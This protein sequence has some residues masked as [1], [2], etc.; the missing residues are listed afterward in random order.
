MKVRVLTALT[1]IVIALG[2]LFWASPW[3]VIALGLVILLLGFQEIARLVGQKPYPGPIVGIATF[4]FV[5]YEASQGRLGQWLPVL[6]FFGAGS[7]IVAVTTLSLVLHRQEVRRAIPPWLRAELSGFWLT[8]PLLCLLALHQLHP[9]AQ[10]FRFETPILMSLV[11]LWAGDTAAILVGRLIGKTPLA[12]DI[13]PKK[14]VEGGVANLLACIGTCF[15]IGYIIHYSWL[16]CLLCGISAGLLGQYGDLFESWI[17]RDAG[18]KDS[19]SILPGHGGLMDR[20]DSMLFTAPA[21]ALILYYF[22]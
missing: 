22:R 4:G 1:L 21:V 5:I 17:K 6:V 13:S 8:G 12:P 15:L 14:T 11:P 3:S 20:I 19:G 9:N 10:T 18:L 7:L 16:P 2:V